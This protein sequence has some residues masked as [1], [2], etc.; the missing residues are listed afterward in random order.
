VFESRHRQDI[1]PSPERPHQLWGPAGLLS[2]DLSPRLKRPRRE[3]THHLV[4]T[5]RMSGALP[6]S[7]YMPCGVYPDNFT[8]QRSSF[9]STSCDLQPGKQINENDTRV[10]ELGSC[11]GISR[12]MQSF[13]TTA[14]DVQRLHNDAESQL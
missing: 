4:P 12:Q 8:F 3:A 5:L 14:E 6:P 9:Q 7:A 1:F 2:G 10:P 11:H 13:H